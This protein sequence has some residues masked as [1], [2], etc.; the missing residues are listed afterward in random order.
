MHESAEKYQ[1]RL[2]S[3]VEGKDTITVLTD[4]PGL[5][6]E[7]I[8]G[9]AHERLVQRPAPDKWCVNEVVG[10]L[11]DDVIATAW[12]YRQMIETI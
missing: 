6:A 1:A 12:R 4:T 7:A 5:I 10:H 9:V 2:T 8:D 3:Y 11:L